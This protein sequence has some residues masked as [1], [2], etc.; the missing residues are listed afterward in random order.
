MNFWLAAVISALIFAVAHFDLN[1]GIVVFPIGL[2]AA[3]AYDQSKSLWS[4]FIIHA[5][6]N[7]LSIILVYALLTDITRIPLV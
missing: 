3:Y 7:L 6:N 2:I 5:V 4:S 1:V